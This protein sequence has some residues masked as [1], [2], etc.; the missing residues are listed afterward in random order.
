MAT[1]PTVY[2]DSCCF[3][4]YVKKEVG[5]LPS[6]RENDS[7]FVKQI[8]EA[9]K[10]GILVAKTSLMAIGECL[11]IEKGETS[12]AE[13]AKDLFRRLLTSGQ[14][15]RLIH[16]TP[17]TPRLMQSF[18]WDHGLVL[19]AVD[20]M[21]F[22]SAIEAQCSEFITSD[23]RLKNAKVAAAIAVLG[24][25]GL[26]MISAPSTASLPTNVTQQPL[27]EGVR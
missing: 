26:R 8:L 27:T 22:A 9:H 4:D 25:M 6:D 12:V 19:G 18:R 16:P 17:R 21:H 3:I 13:D 10:R 11:S 1:R 5:A 14:Y 20:A 7:W 2:L 23:D 15:V 24:G